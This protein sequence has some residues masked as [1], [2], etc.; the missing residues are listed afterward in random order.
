VTRPAWEEAGQGDVAVLLLHGIGGG[1]AVWGAQ[2]S[3]TLQALAGAGFRA[4]ALDLPGYG[5]SAAMGPPDLLA[6]VGAVRAVIARAGAKRVALVGHSMGGMVAQELAARHPGLVD[7]L[8]LACTSAAFGKPDGQWQAQFVAERLAPLDAGLGMTGM[9]R[10]LV[11][12]LLAP[13]APASAREAAVA[14][15]SRVPEATYRSA[16]VAIAGFDRR[17]SLAALGM[18]VLCLAGE[19]DRTAPPE[20]MQR[21][22]AR[23]P[24]GE[25]LCL[26]GAGHLANLDQPGAFDAAVIH[27]LNRHVPPSPRSS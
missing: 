7:A 20:V 14:A 8:V 23:V 1:A 10:R 22:A 2:G 21:M 19:F 27:F 12:A 24:R 11:P 5:A 13:G 26:P 18:P 9:A 15:M 3:G 17:E 4:L 16:L 6:M 25:Y